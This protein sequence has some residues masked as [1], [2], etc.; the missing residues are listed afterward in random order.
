[1]MFGAEFGQYIFTGVFI[2]VKEFFCQTY[3]PLHCTFPLSRVPCGIP[4]LTLE[5]DQSLGKVFVL[6]Y[7][8]F[9][10]SYFCTP[11]W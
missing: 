6:F 1:M 8:I 4:M 3:V 5:S 10:F 7:T 9:T 11:C 2:G